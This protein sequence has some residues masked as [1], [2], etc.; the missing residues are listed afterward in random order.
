MRTK[1]NFNVIIL[2]EEINM[3]WNKV[4]SV[5]ESLSYNE[6]MQLRKGFEDGIN[7][8]FGS[9]RKSVEKG[10]SK[11][12]HGAK[13]R[14]DQS[15][16][17]AKDYY[18]KGKKLAGNAWEAI[19]KFADDISDKIQSGFNSAVDSITSGYEKFKQSISNTI[20][21]ASESITQAY[22]K[23]KDKGEAFL[24]SFKGIVHGAIAKGKIFKQGIVDKFKAMGEKTG[25]WIKQNKESIE[26]TAMEMKS[27]GTEAMKSI[28]DMTLKLLKSGAK[29]ALAT[30]VIAIM[31]VAGTFNLLVKGVQKIGE[32]ANYVK[33]Q[34]DEFIE[35]EKEEWK[36]SSGGWEEGKEAVYGK[37]SENLQYI[38]KF[39]NFKY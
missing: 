29:A 10:A 32:G 39:E 5:N 24:E 18:E 36:N 16:D 19:K 25:E 8:F 26:K 15:V 35:K 30:G 12:F 9:I 20:K 27:T 3:I 34:V 2:T 37:T 21:D 22:E 13:K 28:A 17:K 33:A 31:L 23:M 14:F 38:K 6:R 11:L 7:E 4:Y 1:E